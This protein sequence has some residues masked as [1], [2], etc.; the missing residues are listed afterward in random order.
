MYDS[1]LWSTGNNSQTIQLFGNVLGLGQHEIYV[2]VD[3]DGCTGTSNSFVLT[4]DAC[5]GISELGNLT[6]DVYPNPSNGEIV[7]D[8]NGDSEGFALTVV[9]VNG[10]LVYSERIASVNSNLR[11]AIDLS[12][13]SKGM[14]FLK[15]EDGTE[16]IARKLI[17]Q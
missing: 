3:Q 16:S 4:V 11:K 14:Y 7:L 13:L 6:I 17:I 10:K 8:I 12:T 15:L 9:D 2:T 1:Y 5:A